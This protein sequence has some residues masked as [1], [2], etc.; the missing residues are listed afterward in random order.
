MNSRKAPSHA[1]DFKTTKAIAK[2]PAPTSKPGPTGY[3]RRSPQATRLSTPRHSTKHR[4]FVI[5]AGASYAAGLP[6]ANRLPAHVFG[7]IG[8]APW[9]VVHNRPP[10]SYFNPLS[11]VLQSVLK[12]LSTGG[13]QE[14]WPMDAV[15]ERFGE[16]IRENPQRFGVPFGQLFEATAQL[17]YHRSQQGA[18]SKAY[19]EFVETLTESDLILTFNWDVCLE[20][21]MQRAGKRLQRA[22]CLQPRRGPWLLKLNG[23]VDHLI[24]NT[25]ASDNATPPSGQTRNRRRW[26]TQ[27][28]FLECLNVS[29]PSPPDTSWTKSTSRYEL[30]R[31]H[32]Y[33]LAGY[34]IPPNSGLFEPTGKDAIDE[35]S[36]DV[37][38]FALTHA[39]PEYP[40]I[41]MIGPG[42][43]AG[44]SGWYYDA[45]KSAVAPIA[46]QITRVYVIGYSFPVYDLPLVSLLRD[47]VQAAGS[48][49]ADIVNP[50]ATQLPRQPLQYIFGGGRL[51]LHSS[52]FEGFDWTS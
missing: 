16:L 41:H 21:A 39:L 9:E 17:L 10:D 13:P 15:F 44:L 7:Y 4:L 1:R 34:E 52:G 33:D 43:P 28:P 19:R 51:Q 40:S 22:L 12:E 23:S 29:A 49:P 31:L 14:K 38:P 11:A 27:F 50:D 6:D 18:R 42:T 2:R 46:S 26:W 25:S 5:G 24:V 8:N 30:A 47:I 45:V 3:S 32:T 20:I 36:R 48:P 37:G 35:D